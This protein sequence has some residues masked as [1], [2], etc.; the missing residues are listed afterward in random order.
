[1][2]YNSKDWKCIIENENNIHIYYS[3][4]GDKFRYIKDFKSGEILINLL[5]GALENPINN[6]SLF[7]NSP[8][9][10]LAKQIILNEI[11]NE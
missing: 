4:A 10:I 1:M 6:N 7:N 5:N 3:Y 2:D 9:V 11:K 8:N